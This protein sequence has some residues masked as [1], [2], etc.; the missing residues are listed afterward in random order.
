[1]TGMIFGGGKARFA[2]RCGA[3]AKERNDATVKKHPACGGANR[4]PGFVAAL[5]RY[6]ASRC[7]P[8][9]PGKPICRHQIDSIWSDSA[10]VQIIY[11]LFHM[12]AK[13]EGVPAHQRLG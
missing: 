2:W 5:A 3:S 11:V 12:Q 13:I 10:L 8:R 9:L 6:R 4:L 1:M 7:T